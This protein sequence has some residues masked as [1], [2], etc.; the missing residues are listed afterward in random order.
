MKINNKIAQKIEYGVIS[1]AKNKQ[2]PFSN[3]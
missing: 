1:K 2:R 3:F